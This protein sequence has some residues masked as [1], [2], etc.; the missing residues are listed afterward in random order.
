MSATLGV[1]SLVV[2]EAQVKKKELESWLL[3]RHEMPL[4]PNH[5]SFSLWEKA[6]RTEIQEKRPFLQ[7]GGES[8]TRIEGYAKLQEHLRYKGDEQARKSSSQDFSFSGRSQTKRPSSCGGRL[9]GI[10][11]HS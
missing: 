9:P 6:F 2:F 7:G 1:S 11:F 5:L 8:R 10:P 4:W 3:I